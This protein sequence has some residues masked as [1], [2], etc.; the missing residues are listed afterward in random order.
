MLYLFLSSE[1][2]MTWVTQ[3]T[4]VTIPG[5]LEHGCGTSEFGYAIQRSGRSREL[6]FMCSAAVTD[7]HYGRVCL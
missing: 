3:W 7:C 4:V 6:R 5:V 1:H 2:G